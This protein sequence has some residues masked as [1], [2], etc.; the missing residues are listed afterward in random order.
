MKQNPHALHKNCEEL[1]KNENMY[2]LL[3]QNA[4]EGI[5]VSKGYQIID[6]NKA[7]I[8]ILGYDDLEE[9]KR[10]PF[11]DFVVPEDRLQ[12][13]AKIAE[14]MK[15]DTS[16][17]HMILKMI[18]KNG[19][20]IDVETAHVGL[21]VGEESFTL[22]SF[23]DITDTLKTEENLK[24]SEELHRI[25][26]GNIS[27]AVF[28]TDDTGI[29]T[30]ICPNVNI[31]FGYSVDE[32]QKFDNI[33]GLLGENLY[34]FAELNNR[35][36][37]QNIEKDIVDKDGN[38]HNLLINVKRVAIKDGTVLYTCRD[39]TEL[40]RI[41]EEIVN[42][43]K[44][45]SEN[46]NPVLKVSRD[47][48]IIYANNGSETLLKYWNRNVGQ[49][50]PDAFRSKVGEVY[51]SGVNSTEE[52]EFDTY[53]YTL[54]YT[55]L[56]GT[57]FIN[58]YGFDITERK[59][60]EERLQ[61]RDRLDSL[62]T[63]AGG[64]AHDFNNLL[65]A[66][67]GNIELLRNESENLTDEQRDFLDEASR[68]CRRGAML[69]KN[70]QS[71]S[72]G[73][74]EESTKIDLYQT[75]KNVFDIINSSSDKNIEKIISFKPEEFIV[76]GKP[77]QLHQVF[78]NLGY[79]AVEAIE[80]KGVKPDDFIK[81][82]AAVCRIDEDKRMGMSGG[83]CVHI[84]FEDTGAGMSESVKR[85]AFDPLFTTKERSSQKGQG[86][87]LA[88]VYNIVTRM[89]EGYI[90]IESTEGKGTIFHVFLP[91]A[92]VRS[93]DTPVPTA[94]KK[95]KNATILVVEDEKAVRRVTERMLQKH[96]YDVLTAIDGLEGL[97]VYNAN[98]NKID[99]VMLDLSMPKMSG[100]IFLEKIIDINPNVKVIITSGQS[101][102]EMQKNKQA[103]GYLSKPYT[104]ENMIGVL[105]NVLGE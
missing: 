85:K 72:K 67:F 69:I 27:D 56:S 54:T 28:I 11:I 23:R 103:Q 84:R 30:F 82:S 53:A 45:P 8:K 2:R 90:E 80:R 65:A 21:Q 87:G 48:K 95:K 14:R 7:L 9:F 93:S 62:G 33:T 40:R 66:I 97:D 94:D 16:Y 74:V 39:I 37:L 12:V 20:I 64:I 58:I 99:I 92:L 44:F 89:H 10:H 31:I 60:L 4:L 50:L 61:I 24:W 55:P 59:K 25:T 96:G 35:G 102:E 76:T 49:L 104:I 34:D 15:G 63:L 47:G 32:V 79:N 36:E 105:R 86:L 78:L 77:D 3:F 5:G 68:S 57:N 26:L 42:L 1:T 38:K 19:E 71:L 98:C 46:P 6:A 73:I 41:E 13:Q 22:S 75:V 101:E 18:R 52:I 88:I 29:F 100:K 17:N 83:R 43:A 81:I 51:C 91:L 70:I